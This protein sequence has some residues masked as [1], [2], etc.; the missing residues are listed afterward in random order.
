MEANGLDNL[1]R[2]PLLAPPELVVCNPYLKVLSV[3]YHSLMEVKLS[4]IFNVK[5]TA[6]RVDTFADHMNIVVHHS[7]SGKLFFC[8]RRVEFA[9]VIEVYRVW[10]EAIVTSV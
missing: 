4:C 3:N 10:I 1:A 6:F 5:G 7:H 8:S 9:V 2:S